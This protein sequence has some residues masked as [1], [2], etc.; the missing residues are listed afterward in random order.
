MRQGGEG[1]DAART[2]TGCT[3]MGSIEKRTRAGSATWRAHYRDPTDR[4]RNKSFLRKIDAER[5]LTKIEASKLTGSYVDPKQAARTVRDVAEEHWAAH[6]HHLAADTT[7]FVKRSRL[8][9]H[10]LPVLGDDV[11]AIKPST[12]AAAVARWATTLAPGTVGQVL[13][14]VRQVLDA[15][16]PDGIVASNAAKAVKAPSASCRRDAQLADDDVRAIIAAAP[17]WYLVLVLVGLGLRIIEA[18]GLLVSDIDF[19]RKTV[20]VR[21]QRRPGG[22]LG[23]LKTDS[24]GRE[25]PA[26]EVVLTA[27]AEQVRRWH[28]EDERALSTVTGRILTKARPDTSSMTSRRRPES[29]CRR[30]RAAT[31]LARRWYQPAYPWWQCRGGWSTRAPR[32]RGGSTRT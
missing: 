21:R 16:V 29:T 13:R 10:I 4:Q 6:K 7:R 23:R 14:Q 31:T 22:E 28:R 9:R 11:G 26:N 12:M 30:T 18:C 25:V 3:G 20:H 1:D 2:R 19:L 32:S 8:Y 27:L 5:F 15:A 17:E 24:F